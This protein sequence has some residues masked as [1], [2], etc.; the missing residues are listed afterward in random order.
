MPSHLVNR[1]FVGRIAFEAAGAN[2]PVMSHFANPAILAHGGHH[3]EK[4]LLSCR[5]GRPESV[6]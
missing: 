4:G 3:P 2:G 6:Q 1:W 5:S